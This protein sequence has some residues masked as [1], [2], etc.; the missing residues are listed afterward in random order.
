[1]FIIITDFCRYIKT[2]CTS[3]NTTFAFMLPS[4]LAIP[5]DCH[6]QSQIKASDY[7]ADFLVE[8]K[9]KRFI[10]APYIQK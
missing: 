1:M 9:K 4:R 6:E 2:L 10:L 3:N 5:H 7:L 8:N